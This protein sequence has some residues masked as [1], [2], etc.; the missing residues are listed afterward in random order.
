MKL[1]IS[2]IAWNNDLE[3]RVFQLMKKYGFTGLEIAPT[4]IFPQNP[5]DR[6]SEAKVYAEGLLSK[7]G[8]L[9]S[10]MQSIWYGRQE[11]IFSSTAEREALISYTKKAIDFASAV[12]AGNLVFGCPRNRNLAADADSGVAV[13]FFRE[14]G[15]YAHSRNTVI[16]ME[17]NPPIYNTNYIN[18]TE[19][20]LDLVHAVGSD[21]FKLNFDFGTL[22]HN[23]ESLNILKNNPEFINHIHI[24]EP[25][26]APIQQ[27]EAHV[28]LAKLLR[29]MNYGGF[30]SIEMG[31]QTDVSLIEGCMK[32][33]SEV[34]L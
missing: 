21:G 17:A 3:G 18:T 24:S 20:A 27:R 14:L 10:S 8:F 5:Y 32:Y 22:I 28:V 12:G 30:V 19:E 13:E 23:S 11:N 16:G 29:D 1:S 33:V 25:M 4:K 15:D 31:L 7:N 34:F 9:V 2:N 6:L 26:L